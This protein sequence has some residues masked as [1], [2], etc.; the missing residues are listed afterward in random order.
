MSN[1]FKNDLNFTIICPIEISARELVSKLFLLSKVIDNK[2]GQIVIG[3]KQNCHLTLGKFNN[4]IYI[5]K[6]YHQKISE[7]I[8][9]KIKDRGGLI[10]SL[11]EENAV[12]Y[13]DFSTVNY[14]FPEK[15]F[16]VFD[17]IFLWGNKV[18]D[19][20]KKNR[21]L[22]KNI[23]K[24]YVSGHTKFE[25][26]KPSYNYLYE[27]K[28]KL[29]KEKYGEFI[30]VNTD[31][32]FSNN[33]MGKEEIIKKYSTR[34]TRLE[35]AIKYQQ[36][37]IELFLEMVEFLATK[38]NYNIII[39]PH[40]EESLEIYKYL[41]KKYNNVIVIFEG[42]VIP[43]LIACKRMIHH[44]CTTS[45]EYAMMGKVPISYAAYLDPT[46]STQVPLEISKKIEKKE[47]LLEYI[48]K[49]KKNVL[50]QSK[51]KILDEWFCYN[52]N[53]TKI[54]SEEICKILKKRFDKKNTILESI[55]LYII[56]MYINIK[57]F[58]KFLLLIKKS[59][60]HLNK[61]KGFNYI[62]IK[63]MIAL[64]NKVENLNLKVHLLADEFFLIRNN[65]K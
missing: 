44:D 59:K 12:D 29:L 22:N 56:A 37:Q 27:D 52:K 47:D 25:L 50:E 41:E 16:H 35:G 55:Y 13:A 36:K 45:I 23:K 39:R 1:Y 6:G 57:N 32:G 20:L 34:V 21:N 9:K 64:I 14:R 28:S 5:D 31:F 61:L 17:L 7:K 19:F 51:I 48:I 62:E 8:Y 18:F 63:K 30:L 4:Q 65:D 54:I 49:D 58:I 26:L 43:W 10:I 24:I 40:P 3:S 60:L 15:V 46:Y 42:E 38:I 11:D 2:K 33:I 53:S